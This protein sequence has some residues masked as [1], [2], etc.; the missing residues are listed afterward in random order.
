MNETGREHNFELTIKKVFDEI[1]SQKPKKIA[2]ITHRRPDIDAF[3]SANA[4]RLA[5]LHISPDSQVHVFSEGGV[6]LK[7][8]RVVEFLN[9]S[10]SS[11][12]DL[13]VDS[14]W[15][16]FVDVGGIEATGLP[17][18][19]WDSLSGVKILLDHHP[20]FVHYPYHAEI[21]EGATSTSEIILEL[22]EVLG[23]PLDGRT[24]TSLMAGL[25]SDSAGLKGA[26]ANTVRNLYKLQSKGGDIRSAWDLVSRKMARDE[27]IARIKSAQRCAVQRISD[28][29][30][31]YSEIGSFNASSAS[32]LIALGADL[33]IVFTE[34][35]DTTKVSLRASQEFYEKTGISLGALGVEIS[36]ALGGYGG[37]HRMAAAFTVQ[38]GATETRRFVQQFM[39]RYLKERE[40]SP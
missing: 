6:P 40:I 1:R 29:V 27:R 39:I 17:S 16:F 32:S 22:Y 34:T 2:V 25:I 30:I 31:V 23:L 8:K 5:L 15:L 37:G 19:F 35:E 13:L 21:T 3:V 10:L 4:L 20:N 26:N 24:A 7:S 28:L 38:R 9:S 18:E 36:K 12:R 33:A 11:D 14:P